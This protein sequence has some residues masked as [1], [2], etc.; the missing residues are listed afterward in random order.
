MPYLASHNM[1]LGS[2]SSTSKKNYMQ[3]Y[4]IIIFHISNIQS[5]GYY[6]SKHTTVGSELFLEGGQEKLLS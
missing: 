5:L 4:W 1:A 3:N 6:K 2:I